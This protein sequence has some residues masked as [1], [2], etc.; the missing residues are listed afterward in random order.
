MTKLKEA[1]NIGEL[2]IVSPFL[3]TNDDGEILFDGSVDGE[4]LKLPSLKMLLD[5]FAAWTGRNDDFEI[6][7]NLRVFDPD[8]KDE[9]G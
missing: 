9:Y 7:E 1:S 8:A 4:Y 3:H 5:R 6:G 2:I